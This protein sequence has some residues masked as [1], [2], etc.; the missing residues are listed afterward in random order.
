MPSRSRMNERSSLQQLVD[1]H[2]LDLV[3]GHRRRRLRDR[4]A[5]AV[6]AQ[7]LDVA[8]VVDLEH[9][10]CSSSPQSGLRVLELEVGRSSSVAPVVGALVVLEDLL[11]V[12][13]VHRCSGEDPPDLVRGRR[14]A[15]R[16][17][18]A[19]CGR[20]TT[21]ASSR[22]TP[23]R[24]ISGCAQWWPARTQTPSRP[25]ISA[26]SCGW[27]PSSANETSAPRRSASAGPWIVSPAISRQALERVGGE[28]ALV[29][30][31]VLHA[32]ARRGSRPRRRGRSPRRS[33]D[34]P[35]SNF[36][37]SSAQ[38]ISSSET[39]AIMCPPP[40]NGGIASS[41]SRRPCRTPTPV[42]P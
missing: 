26:T 19:W 34:V 14:R 35:A 3:G 10:P 37:G 42:G 38:R 1:R 32:E 2:A 40:R 12:Q 29:R 11:A 21:R 25:R 7:V 31:D 24:F 28:L 39:T 6:E 30:A 15:R 5:V 13:V 4:A 41:S 22:A 20:R 8:V 18:R 17:R 33:S 23:R 9:R 16:R 27:T 36:A